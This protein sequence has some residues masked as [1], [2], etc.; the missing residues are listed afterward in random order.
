MTAYIQRCERQLFPFLTNNKKKS[1]SKDYLKHHIKPV[2]PLEINYK[3]IVAKHV[4]QLSVIDIKIYECKRLLLL[5]NQVID[6]LLLLNRVVLR[7]VANCTHY[8]NIRL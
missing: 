6:M 8:S 3:T 1:A 5:S 7:L 4:D 2:K